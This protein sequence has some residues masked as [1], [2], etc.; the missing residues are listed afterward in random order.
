MLN[1]KLYFPSRI[2]VF[3]LL[4][5]QTCC[6]I[7][8]VS[9]LPQICIV[10][11]AVLLKHHEYT[12]LWSSL[13]L[14]SVNFDPIQ[15]VVPK[16]GV[17]ALSRDYGIAAMSLCSDIMC[18]W[19]PNCPPSLFLVGAHIVES[20]GTRLNLMNEILV[21]VVWTAIDACSVIIGSS[22][23]E[24]LSLSYRI[25]SSGSNSSVLMSIWLYCYIPLQPQRQ[26]SDWHWSVNSGHSTT[27]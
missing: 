22:G 5:N 18:E 27:T 19:I 2:D 7:L 15:E 17:G 3:P 10:L 9:Q 26:L 4:Q 1:C 20:L 16:V 21:M 25:C 14:I 11:K 23:I 24:K 6:M 13:Q 8:K 12:S